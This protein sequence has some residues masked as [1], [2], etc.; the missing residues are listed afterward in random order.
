MPKKN[1]NDKAEEVI[2][3]NP[4]LDLN[5]V[6]LEVI[7]PG[8]KKLVSV[9]WKRNYHT[10]CSCAGHTKALEP[11][12]WIVILTDE[13]NPE[14]LLKLFSA[15]GRFN[16]SLGKNGKLPKADKLWVLVPQMTAGGLAVYLRPHSL[17]EKSNKQEINRLR[18][19]GEKLAFFMEK[20]CKDIFYP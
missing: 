18:Q 13:S 15:V 6:G 20:K 19:L 16:L 4:E 14:P 8:I 1:S 11:L 2:G 3:V 5:H 10:V 12:P 9:L 7:E 17:N